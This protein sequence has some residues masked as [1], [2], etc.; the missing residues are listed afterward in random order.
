[1]L[2]LH[3]DFATAYLVK[4]SVITNMCWYL[5]LDISRVRKSVHTNSIGWVVVILTNGLRSLAG[6]LRLIQR[7]QRTQLCTLLVIFG[8]YTL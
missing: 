7:S 4:W 2:P 1:M 6:V 8:Q 3:S 5:P